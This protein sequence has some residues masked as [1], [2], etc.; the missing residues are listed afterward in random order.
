MHFQ[1][2]LNLKDEQFG[3]IREIKEKEGFTLLVF[4]LH[5]KSQGRIMLRSSDPKAKPRTLGE[6]IAAFLLLSYRKIKLRN[7]LR[8]FSFWLVLLPLSLIGTF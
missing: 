6:V 3:R 4:N 2:V 5:P 7:I 8:P 1:G